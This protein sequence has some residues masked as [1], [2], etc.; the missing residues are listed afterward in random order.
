M[1]IGISGHRGLSRATSS[2]IEEALRERLAAHAGD[3]LVGISSLADG[4]DQLFAR[5]VLEW[6]GH[7][8][9]IVP[10]AEYRAGLPKTAWP[11]YDALTSQASSIAHLPYTES[12]EEAHMAAGQ[13]L[14]AGADLLLAVWDG[15]PARGFG[16]TADVVAHAR[17]LGVPVDVVWPLGA[18]RD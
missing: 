11:E 4:P 14:V 18:T 3:D 6:G 10:A 15:A 7:L 17:C 13:A 9:V 8:E 12:S 1:R 16:G 2:L 5:A